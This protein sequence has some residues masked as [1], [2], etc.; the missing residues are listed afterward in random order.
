MQSAVLLLRFCYLFIRPLPVRG[1]ITFISRQSDI[2]S[3]D[4]RLLAEAVQREIPQ[5]EIRILTKE[6]KPGFWNKLSF[7]GHLLSQM[8]H[9]ST[10]RFTVLDGYCI[11]ASVL[12]HKRDNTIIQMWHASCA[13]KKFGW[14]TVGREAGSD[15]ETAE[16][17]Q[18]HH[19]YDYVLAPSK[20]TGKIYCE[21]FHTTEDKLQFMGPAHFVSLTRETPSLTQRIHAVY[22]ELEGKINLLYVPTFRKGSEIDLTPLTEKID[23]EKYNLIVRPHVLAQIKEHRSEAI[24]DT[25]FSTY[26]WIKTADIVITDYSSLA[27]DAAVANKRIYFYTYD[28]EEY[29]TET[30]LNIRFEEELISKYTACEAEALM[31]LIQEPY[32]YE[33]LNEFKRRYVEIIPERACEDFADL[34]MKIYNENEKCRNILDMK[35]MPPLW[36]HG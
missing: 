20:L 23:F 36:L 12:S 28:R 22:P 18:M 13:L 21:A 35:N 27:V 10:S 33:V 14:Q 1:K 11:P 2:P 30:G 24:F 32:D 3:E 34:L 8:Y 16:I 26:E 9:I 5:L 17:M 4:I 7:C 29:E 31:T 15:P 25:V 6:L 19:N